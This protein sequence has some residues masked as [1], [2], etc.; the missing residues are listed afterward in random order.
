MKVYMVLFD[1][2]TSNADDS[3]IE[4][5]LFDS[6][7]KAHNRFEE[8]IKNEKNPKISWAADAFDEKGKIIDGYE[9]DE[10]DYGH[11]YDCWWNLTDKNDWYRHDF[12]DLKE[13]EVK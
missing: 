4:I 9:F 2:S 8:I 6:Y 13:L 7:E 1:W 12:L 10:H 3:A 11:P 5:E